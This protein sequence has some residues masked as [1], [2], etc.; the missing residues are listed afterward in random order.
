MVVTGNL[1]THYNYRKCDA[2]V[3]ASDDRIEITTRTSDGEA[4]VD[5]V[6][7]LSHPAAL[8]LLSPFA[9]LKTPAVS[10]VRCRSPSTTSR[11]RTRSS[12]SGASARTG[13]R[14]R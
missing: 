4:D 7:D 8:S 12:P 1:L 13:T 2:I 3:R 9:D 11:R 10:P 6:A 14:N 5:V